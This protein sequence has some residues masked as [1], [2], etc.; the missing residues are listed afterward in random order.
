V[1]VKRSVDNL[2]SGSERIVSRGDKLG[3]FLMLVPVQLCCQRWEFHVSR[4]GNL[5]TPSCLPYPHP[6]IIRVLF[7]YRED[8]TKRH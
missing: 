5:D 4:C 2:V 1:I 6:L 7:K 8:S 3:L